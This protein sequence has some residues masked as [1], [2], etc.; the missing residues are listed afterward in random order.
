V[1]R[2]APVDRVLLLDDHDAAFEIAAVGQTPA[3]LGNQRSIVWIA[4]LERDVYIEQARLQHIA[5]NVHRAEHVAFAAAEHKIDD[6]AVLPCVDPYFA[7]R[8]FRIE[9]AK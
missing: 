8:E 7:A 1:D 2:Y 9:I 3:Q 5:F 4:R 6:G